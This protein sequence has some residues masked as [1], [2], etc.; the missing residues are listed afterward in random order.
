MMKRVSSC[1][2]GARR[3]MKRLAAQVVR[4]AASRDGAGAVEFAIVAPILLAV[5]ISSFEVTVAINLA[6]KVSKSAGSIADIVTQQNSV[7]QAFLA[8]MMEAARSNL[9]PY[10]PTSMTMRI[11]GISIDAS[12]TAKVLWSWDQSG[13]RPYAFGSNVAGMPSELV[14]PGTFVVKAE[15]T[16]PHTML[17]FIA[18]TIQNEA[19]TITISKDFYFRQRLGTEVA[20]S[21]C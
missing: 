16:V 13:A 10:E 20:C 9:A 3:Q 14:Y 7:N 6:R 4:V 8:T 11:T 19:R 18:S 15:I 21:D 5:Y 12:S 1:L 2:Y 17:L